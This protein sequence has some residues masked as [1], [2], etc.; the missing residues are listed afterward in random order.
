MY[1]IQTLL[2]QETAVLYIGYNTGQ[3]VLFPPKEDGSYQSW[4]TSAVVITLWIEPC[5]V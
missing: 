3:I 4:R 1:A 5:A 2:Y